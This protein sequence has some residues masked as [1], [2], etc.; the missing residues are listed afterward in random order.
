MSLTYYIIDILI[1][2]YF[3]EQ[4]NSL[5]SLHLLNLYSDPVC[6]NYGICYFTWLILFFTQEFFM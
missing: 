5:L 4:V 3:C 1:I 2:R 6:F